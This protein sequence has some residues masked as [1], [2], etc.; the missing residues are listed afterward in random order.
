MIG[1]AAQATIWKVTY[2]FRRQRSEN[3]QG[4]VTG[5]TLVLTADPAGDDLRAVTER[6]VMGAKPVEKH[7]DFRVEHVHRIGDVVGLV[8]LD[9]PDSGWGAGL[10]ALN[11]L[12][13]VTAE[14]D[15]LRLQLEQ[16]QSS[17]EGPRP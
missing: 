15:R 1:T 5:E 12:A 8:R 9:A 13:E 17:G 2:S 4:Y 14:R 3:S 11:E 7:F 6:F 16:L 10:A